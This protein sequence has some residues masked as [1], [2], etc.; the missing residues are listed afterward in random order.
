MRRKQAKGAKALL[1]VAL[2]GSTAAYGMHSFFERLSTPDNLADML[3]P[4]E[5]QELIAE[6]GTITINSHGEGDVNVRDGWD[7]FLARER[8]N[9]PLPPEHAGDVVAKLPDGTTLEIKE[10]AVLE[11]DNE[12]VLIEKSDLT[13][14]SQSSL[15][16]KFKQGTID[17]R[18]VEGL[19]PLEK[20]S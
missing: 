7:M 1:A 15:P 12:R 19:T 14:K 3:T 4:D 10:G 5:K 8:D 16:K 20:A 13:K 2:I 9:G 6:D 17:K 18:F 11:S